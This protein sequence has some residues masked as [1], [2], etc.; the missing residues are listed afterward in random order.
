MILTI[1]KRNDELDDKFTAAGDDGTVGAPIRVLPAD[2]VV[3]LVYADNI[4]SL[5]A[6]AACVY[7]HTI[8]I[9]RPEN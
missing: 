7:E 8:Q 1:G 4:L 2:A 3:L 6:G 9:L 5:L